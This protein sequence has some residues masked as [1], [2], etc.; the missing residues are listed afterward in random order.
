MLVGALIGTEVRFL[1][2]LLLTRLV[3]KK[4]R[5]LKSGANL[6]KTIMNKDTF[7]YQLTQEDS[8][9][10]GESIKVTYAINNGMITIYEIAMLPAIAPSVKSWFT[11]LF[12][13]K[14]AA[15]KHALQIA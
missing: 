4:R 2:P 14:A 10:P 13:I 8:F 5:G 12:E 1:H 11:L 3:I 6:K 9:F 7:N 15:R